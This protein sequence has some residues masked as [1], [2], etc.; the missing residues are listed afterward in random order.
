MAQDIED[1]VENLHKEHLNIKDDVHEVKLNIKD[2]ASIV[3][4]NSEA[5]TRNNKELHNDMKEMGT[6]MKKFISTVT[7][8]LVDNTSIK[9]DVSELQEKVEDIKSI[10]SNGCPLLREL[11]VKFDNI[12]KE[13]DKKADTVDLENTK[14]DVRDNYIT[15]N[16]LVWVIPTIITTLGGV[17]AYLKG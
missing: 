1:R 16:K 10:R 17:A 7:N 9:K 12:Q 15:T 3:A 8:V 13:V 6:E 2:L 4:V 11:S 14:K 5:M